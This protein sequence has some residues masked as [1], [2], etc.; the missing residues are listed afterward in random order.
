MARFTPG[1]ASWFGN[2][3]LA[4]KVLGVDPRRTVPAF[5]SQTFQAWWRGRAPGGDGDRGE[6]V[7]FVDE[8]VNYTE[9]AVGIAAV[10]FLE[11]AGYRVLAEDGLDS[12]RTHLSKGLVRKARQ[13]F[14]RS[15]GVLH[16]HALRG[17]PIIGLEPSAILGFRDEAPDLM[18]DD[19][20]RQ[21]AIEVGQQAL[22][23]EEFVAREHAAG[24]L[25]RV[26]FRPDAPTRFLLHGHCHQKTLAST[27]PTR[28]ALCIIPGAQVEEIPSGCCGMAGS[29]GYHHYDVSMQIGEL[30]LFPAVREA[31]EDV[32]VVAPGTSCRHQIH[33]GTERVAWHPAQILRDALESEATP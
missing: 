32:V 3:A 21:R 28:E 24:R 20:W 10:E 13:V 29:F 1:I 12:G 14:R 26:H 31:P 23:F 4:K 5:A 17:L 27:V 9:P 33:D 15:V 22:L 16:P 6:V 30:V 8:F 11:A 18:D 2:T 25:D 19:D 7:L